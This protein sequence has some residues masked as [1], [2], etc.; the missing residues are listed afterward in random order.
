MSGISPNIQTHYFLSLAFNLNK[1]MQW[2]HEFIITY[3][4][5]NCVYTVAVGK[6]H[7]WQIRFRTRQFKF[8]NWPTGTSCAARRFISCRT[9]CRIRTHSRPCKVCTHNLGVKHV[10]VFIFGTTYYNQTVSQNLWSCAVERTER[11]IVAVVTRDKSDSKR[12]HHY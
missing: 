1:N 6:L 9:W 8:V 12:I 3:K 11:T 2:T 4:L 7:I 5:S 10:S